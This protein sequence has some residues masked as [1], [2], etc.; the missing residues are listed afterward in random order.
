MKINFDR[1]TQEQK[2]L[3]R[4]AVGEGLWDHMSNEDNLP[5]AIKELLATRL[6]IAGVKVAEGEGPR[7]AV[8][9]KAISRNQPLTLWFNEQMDNDE[10]L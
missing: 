3:L 7:K 4:S 8:S 6:R 2:T 1:L 5:P 9:R 10:E